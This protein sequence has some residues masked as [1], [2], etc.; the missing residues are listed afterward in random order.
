VYGS[1]NRI[2]A[3]E[4]EGGI[5]KG[6]F[7]PSFLPMSPYLELEVGGGSEKIE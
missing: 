3:A 1:R 6:F 2:K 4:I 7:F 5:G